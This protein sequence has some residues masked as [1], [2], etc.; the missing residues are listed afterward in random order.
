MV[1]RRQRST[2]R[3]NQGI[4]NGLTSQ[5]AS[6]PAPDQGRAPAIAFMPR[7][8]PLAALGSGCQ[9]V[10]W[11]LTFAGPPRSGRPR[12]QHGVESGR[13]NRHGPGMDRDDQLFQ[14]YGL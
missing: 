12:R 14:P 6:A 13:L 7:N 4:S 2:A 11:N 10:A 9:L 1:P 3:G 5:T 8:T